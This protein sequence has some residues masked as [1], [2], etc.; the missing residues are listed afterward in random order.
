MAE[1]ATK[2]ASRKAWEQRNKDKIAAKNK[3]YREKNP[4]ARRRSSRKQTLK[5]YGLTPAEYDAMLEL[6]DGV[7]AICRNECSTGQS[8]AVDHCHETG[9]VRG[10]LCKA[11]NRGIG[12]LGDDPERVVAAAVYLSTTDDYLRALHD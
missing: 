4:E 7:C 1:S 11:C 5:Q 3:R 6:Q 8:L 9:R 12:L 2:R 10:L